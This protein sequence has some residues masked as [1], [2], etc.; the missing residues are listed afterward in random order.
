MSL[1]QVE[2]FT[3]MNKDY[4]KSILSKY[5]GHD[6]VELVDFNVSAGAKKGENF[7]SAVY[8]VTLK[9]LIN[10]ET[11]EASFILKTNSS[12]SAIAEMLEEM[13]TFKAETNIYANILPQCEKLLNFKLAP[14]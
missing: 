12:S 5:E 10:N 11:K 4:F 2:N 14:R 9:Y 3:W 13:G 1:E 8:R 7:A 6:N